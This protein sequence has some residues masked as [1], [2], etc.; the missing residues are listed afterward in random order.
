MDDGLLPPL[1]EPVGPALD[2]ADLR[3]AFARGEATG[4][5]D[6]FHVEGSVLLAAPALAAAM[7]IAP[8]TVL[9]R[10]DV[11]PDMEPLKRSV[12]DALAAEGLT[13]LDEETLLAT[14]VAVQRLGFRASSWDLWGRDIDDAFA[15]LRSAA[16][17][18]LLGPPIGLDE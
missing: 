1:G 3:T 6:R 14:P 15:A 2:E 12:E 4:H 13:L 5:S 10:L 9:V 7:R 18:D 8:G 11:P 16:V 17:G